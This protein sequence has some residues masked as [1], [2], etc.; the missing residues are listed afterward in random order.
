LFIL[1]FGAEYFVL[2]VLVLCL[3]TN[4]AC[5]S[6]TTNDKHEPMNQSMSLDCPFLIAPSVFSKVYSTT[7]VKVGFLR[8]CGKYLHGRIIS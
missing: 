7:Y 3:A 1:V 6:S 8:K 4:V 5:V 2:F